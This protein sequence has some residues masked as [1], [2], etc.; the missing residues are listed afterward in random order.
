[1]SESTSKAAP[2]NVV[3]GVLLALAAVFVAFG[4]A[5]LFAPA[6]LAAY[7]DLE[8][9]S[10]LALI[11]LRAFY[12]GLELGFGLF[13]GIAAMRKSWQ[14]P[15]LMAALLSLLGVA[16]ARIYGISVEGNPGFLVFVLLATEIAGVVA[17]TWGLSQARKAS[18]AGASASDVESAMAELNAPSPLG[19]KPTAGKTRAVDRTQRI[20]ERTEKL[21]LDDD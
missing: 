5:F 11:E 9:K 15:A 8:A 7:V 6:K 19:K 14:V 1:M 13:L 21:R 2:E 16:G 3:R 4:V 17:A 20:I 10:R 12:G 18:K